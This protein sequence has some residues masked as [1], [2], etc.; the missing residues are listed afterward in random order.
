MDQVKQD[1]GTDISVEEKDMGATIDRE[2]NC[3]EVKVTREDV[4]FD[5]G[6]TTNDACTC[7]DT[8][9]TDGSA[10]ANGTK[11]VDLEAAK[12]KQDDSETTRSITTDGNDSEEKS[13][14][15]PAGAPDTTA[16]TEDGRR[17]TIDEV[18]S[19]SIS[20]KVTEIETTETAETST[21]TSRIIIGVPGTSSSDC[22]SDHDL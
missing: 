21:P 13:H 17:K 12:K 6:E 10:T 15:T 7:T 2:T 20:S 5:E 19:T 18:A 22:S 16:A 1:T 14:E 3:L 4:D 8:V 9:R 11:F